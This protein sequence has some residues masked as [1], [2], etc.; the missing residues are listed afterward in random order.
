MRR[1]RGLN[2]RQLGDRRKRVV[3]ER[4]GAKRC[5][6]GLDGRNREPM[7]RDVVRGPDQNDTLDCFDTPVQGCKGR[8]GHLARIEVGGMRS[9]DRLGAAAH[10]RSR[11]HA[12]EPADLRPKLMRIGI[13]EM[14][15]HGRG[16]GHEVGCSR[17]HGLLAFDHTPK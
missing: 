8:R 9:D 13:I 7:K 10:H 12:E 4:N 15:C 16:A 11:R 5:F 3:V 1:V 17:P 14:S 6:K 2:G